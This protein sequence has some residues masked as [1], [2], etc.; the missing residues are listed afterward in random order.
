MINQCF[1][2]GEEKE[3]N[4]RLTLSLD[5]FVDLMGNLGLPYPKKMDVAVPAN[6]ACGFCD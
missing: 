3:H 2:A 4:P 6:L 5:G 1:H